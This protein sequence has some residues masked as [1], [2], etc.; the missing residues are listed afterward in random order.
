[1]SNQP[2][3]LS[4]SPRINV[5]QEHQVRYWME[6]FGCSRTELEAAVKEVGW[7]APSVQAHLQR[8]R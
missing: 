8:K 3:E 2:R 6:K 1:M 4:R 5:N 7:M